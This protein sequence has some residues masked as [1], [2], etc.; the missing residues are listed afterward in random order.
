MERYQTI[1]RT[2]QWWF[3][4]AQKHLNLSILHRIFFFVEIDFNDDDTVK[5]TP[6]SRSMGMDKVKHSDKGKYVDL[7]DLTV[8]RAKMKGLNA[9]IDKFL[10][11]ATE[12]ERRKQRDSDMKILMQDTTHYAGEERELALVIKVDIMKKITFRN[13][14]LT[15][16]HVLDNYPHEAST[17]LRHTRLL[18]L[19]A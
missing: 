8:M 11:V 4:K 3:K 6:P 13:T 15:P 7:D 9:R 16:D 18:D 1:R 17:V 14:L 2:Y 10:R 19:V 5:L 12:R